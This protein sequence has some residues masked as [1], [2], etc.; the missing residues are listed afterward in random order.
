MTSRPGSAGLAEQVPVDKYQ[1]CHQVG[2]G[3]FGL[4]YLMVHK[5]TKKQYVL[6]KVRLARQSEWQRRASFS[7]IELVAGLQH[8]FIVPFIHSWVERG[9]TICCVYGYCEGGDLTGVIQRALKQGPLSEDTLKLWLCQILMALHHVHGKRVLHRD[10]KPSNV[11]LTANGNI[12]IGDFGLATMRKGGD[13]DDH[14]VV[15]TPQYMSPELLAKQPTSFSADIWSLGCVMYELTALRPAFTAFNVGG[16]I[17]KIKTGSTAALSNAHYSTEWCA[18]VRSMLRKSPD[19]RPSVSELMNQPLLGAAM[20]RARQHVLDAAPDI[21]LPPLLELP[22]SPT[23]K[24]AGPKT[25]RSQH[26]PGPLEVRQ[27]SSAW[28]ADAKS[29]CKQD[30]QENKDVQQPDA[31]HQ[32]PSLHRQPTALRSRS[33]LLRSGCTGRGILSLPLQPAFVTPVCPQEPSS[34]SDTTTV[35]QMNDGQCRRVSCLEP[36]NIVDQWQLLP[37][38]LV[39][40]RRVLKGRFRRARPLPMLICND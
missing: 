27:N 3:A 15:G 17:Q 19:K 20:M 18:L 13:S 2:R 7:E 32:Q 36:R 37:S 1:V 34:H 29:S 30:Y 33:N 9:H 39:R 4:A 35:I 38:P 11:F 23:R 31:C 12:Q 5:D 21:S 40:Q 22:Q 26:S 14:S 8:P 28:P 6:K 10:L 24:F 16:L 25:E